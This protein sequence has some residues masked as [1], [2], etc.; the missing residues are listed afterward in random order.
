MG[1]RTSERGAS[2]IGAILLVVIL[3]MLATVSLSLAV[4]ELESH[5]AAQDEAVARHLAEAGA[6]LVLR[7]FHDPSSVPTEAVRN[8][9]ARKHEHQDGS[10]SFFDANGRSQFTG[11][12][13]RPDIVFNA[14]RPA[15]DRLLNDPASGWLRSLSSL[16][17]IHALAVYGPTRPGLLCTVQVTASAR[18]LTRTLAVQLGELALPPLQSAVEIGNQGPAPS[19]GTPLPVKVHWGD[20]VVNGGVQ[21]EPTSGVRQ[22]RWDYETMKREALR[23]GTY[24][25]RG[26]D[27]LLYRHGAIEP[28]L[29]VTVDDVF[30]SETVGD[31]HGLVFVDTLDQTPPRADNLGSLTVR[32]GYAEGVFILNAHVNFAPGGTGKSVPALG[33]PSDAQAETAVPAQLAGIHLRG[34]LVTPGDVTID[35][36]PRVH[37]A[38]VV[39]GK[40]APATGS[41]ARLEVWYDDDLRR[42]LIRGVPLVYQAPGTWLEKYGE[43]RG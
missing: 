43:R 11:T 8:L 41:M 1:K 20:L 2:L 17:R 18:G 25:A 9:L 39:G 40:I 21:Q 27:G 4:Q 36:Q 42:R 26:Q 10:P 22:T 16:G 30:R 37:G 14:A 23:H 3:S 33:P 12:E 31:H 7:W 13:T 24:Y 29:G 35:G 5:R 28:G 6:G 19:D 15:D 34:V 32:T 38:V